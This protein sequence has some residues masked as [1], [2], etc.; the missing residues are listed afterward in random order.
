MTIRAE[1]KAS[2]LT[3]GPA[4]ERISVSQANALLADYHYLGPVRSAI[5]AFGHTE[6]ATVWGVP[7]SR[8]WHARLYAAGFKAIEL[9]RMVGTPQHQ[10]ATSALL[11]SSAKLLRSEYDVLITYADP[12]QGHSGAVY[13]AANWKEFPQRAQPDGWEWRLDGR[14]VSRKRFY[15]EFGTSAWSVVSAAYGTRL[16]RTHDIPKRRFYFLFDKG[17]EEAL[18]AASLKVKTWGSARIAKADG[19]DLA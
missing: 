14:I 7:R 16:T 17:R 18:L 1:Y 10:W 9:I 8:I 2:G 11:S 4:V 12:M 15:S 5:A 6:G 19:S 3:K 13:R